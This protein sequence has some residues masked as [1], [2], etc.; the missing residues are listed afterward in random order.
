MNKRITATRA[1]LA[2]TVCF[3]F[4]HAAA[5][6]INRADLGRSVKLTILVDKVMQPTA[7]WVTEEWMVKASADAGFNVFSPRVGHERLDEVR[8]VT[9]WCE[10]HGIFHMPWMR[11]SLTA[12]DGSRGDG[13]RLVWASGTEQPLWSPNS[14]EFWEWTSK[15]IIEYA[16]MSAENPHIMGVFLD[17]ENYAPGKEGNL[18]AL[19]YDDLILDKFA[20]A[21][22]I[23]LPELALGVRKSWI[24]ERNL[25]DEFRGFQIG[26]WRDRCRALRKAV[27]AHDPAFQFC[28]YPAPGTAFMVEAAY[29]EWATEPAPLILADPSTYGRPSRFFE[30]AASL[31]KNRQR[32]IDN[33]QVPAQSGI[34]FIYSGGID[35]I[36][37]G[38]D[39]E[40]SGKNAV[41]ISEITGGYWIFY[42]GPKY[43]EDHPD[44]FKWFTWANGHIAAGNFDSWHEP[45]REPDDWSLAIFDGVGADL[46]PRLPEVTGERVELAP[47][48]LRGE[49][50]IVVAAKAGRPV[51]LEL[52]NRPL[53]DYESSLVWE[54]RDPSG[55]K[56]ASGRI[57]HAES[58]VARFTP[59]RDGPYLLGASSGRCWYTVTAADVPIGL[60]ARQGIGLIHGV[61]R[62]YFYVPE[63]LERFTIDAKGV[64]GETVRVNVFDPSGV[65]AATAQTSSRRESVTLDV[66]VGDRAGAVWSLQTTKADEGG[67][68][69]NS[70][71][72]DPALSP[73][74]S[75]VPGHVFR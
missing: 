18:Y 47:F 27:D 55:G 16:K 43:G 28:I 56:L 62:M 73:T 46:S 11:G 8:D 67:L 66:P 69:D 70:L 30:Q 54:I 52:R 14:D 20:K 42:E 48:G 25:S 3:A 44:Y 60:Y 1:L 37:G 5:G 29:R 21:R 31:A 59:E 64:G 65:Q 34:P 51:T 12:P 61:E 9:A 24:E 36:V 74:L 45:R 32:L 38:A 40:F 4:T 6:P 63:G 41:M 7:D 71:T 49:N 19:S 13:K 10:K 2:L 15:Y 23:D 26:H 50:L 58:G 68:E 39:P 72:L 53:G 22:G 57:P 33:M 17:Y 75:L 35:P